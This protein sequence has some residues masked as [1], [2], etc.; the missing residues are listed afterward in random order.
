VRKCWEGRACVA[1]Q[2]FN[3]SIA[4]SNPTGTAVCRSGR[5]PVAKLFDSFLPPSN[6]GVG[7][8]SRQFRDALSYLSCYQLDN[9][10]CRVFAIVPDWRHNTQS[11]TDRPTPWRVIEFIVVS[12]FRLVSDGQCQQ[13]RG[14]YA[15]QL[16]K[17]AQT[18]S[19]L[20]RTCLRTTRCKAHMCVRS[21]GLIQ[22]RL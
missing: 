2:L 19:S 18:D 6:L 13:V 9:V 1:T 17:S 7:R 4:L 14:M 8:A 16:G 20:A 5:F 11:H 3:S 22:T 15:R 10:G 21:H 12:I